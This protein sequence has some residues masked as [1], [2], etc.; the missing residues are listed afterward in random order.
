MGRKTRIQLAVAVAVIAACGP[1]GARAVFT[2]RQARLH[3]FYA[4]WFERKAAAHRTAARE[5][6]A[7]GGEAMIQV[8]REYLA[9]SEAETQRAGYHGRLSR[10]YWNALIR[11]WV[12]L[13]VEPPAAEVP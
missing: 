10:R 1:L 3:D 2:R 5:C 6:E 9:Q 13:P 7:Y 8:A 4:G 12:A 11:P